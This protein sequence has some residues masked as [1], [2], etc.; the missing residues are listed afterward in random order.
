MLKLS[1][2]LSFLF[3]LSITTSVQ[4]QGFCQAFVNVNYDTPHHLKYE[5]PLK[6]PGGYSYRYVGDTYNDSIASVAV[7][8]GC[9]L[10]VWSNSDFLGD[11]W[12]IS[13]DMPD[14]GR[15]WAKKISS[16]FCACN[17]AAQAPVNPQS[18][19]PV[20][21]HNP[22]SAHNAPGYANAADPTVTIPPHSGARQ[23]PPG[24]AGFTGTVK[25]CQ[26]YEYAHFHGGLFN[27]FANNRPISLGHL[28]DN[29]AS[30]VVV[31]Q[32][33][34]LTIYQDFNF[35]KRAN[36][37]AAHTVA[38]NPASK[39]FNPGHYRYIGKLWDDQASSAKCLCR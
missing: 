10:K 33:C 18:H 22:Q 19:Y 15:V 6:L 1:Q 28:W 38:N 21:G 23:T 25:A 31:P 11:T 16:M 14:I 27:V 17:N 20:P 13:E 34:Q 4:S 8:P 30:S 3:L 5:P 24:H 7:D 39:V 9:S 2:K 36:P 29:R 35:G 37:Y 32:G 12:T 26:L